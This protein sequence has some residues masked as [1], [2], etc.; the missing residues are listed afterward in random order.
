M[1]TFTAL[2]STATVAA[3]MGISENRVRQLAQRPD[4][5]EA[6]LVPGTRV[7]LYDPDEIAAFMR[8][9]RPACLPGRPRRGLPRA[10][11]DRD[12]PGHAE[13]DHPHPAD[14]QLDPPPG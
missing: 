3:H 11:V 13:A 8:I 12:E 1:R 7:S 9:P 6:Y 2:W 4:F 10:K 5:P 14:G